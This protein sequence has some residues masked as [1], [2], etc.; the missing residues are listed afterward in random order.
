MSALYQL[1]KQFFEQLGWDATFSF[2]KKAYS[3]V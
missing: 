2:L 1:L 3:T